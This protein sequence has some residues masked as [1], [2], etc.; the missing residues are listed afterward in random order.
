VALSNRFCEALA[1]A[2]RL[3]AAQR[4]KLSGSPYIGHLLRVTGIALEHGADEDEAIAAVLHD[5]VEDQGGPAT[6]RRIADT[7]GP[8]VAEIVDGCTDSDQQPKPPWRGRKEG[9]LA[10][11]REASPSVRLVA[12]SDKLDNA[13]SILSSYLDGGEA[14]W[15]SFAAGATACSGIC[16]ASSRPSKSRKALLWS[17]SWIARC[18]RS[19]GPSATPTAVR[20]P[21]TL[22]EL[23]A[24][25]RVSYPVLHPTLLEGKGHG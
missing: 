25:A 8:R 15:D 1:Y 20:W 24:S 11:L 21:R 12:A 4:R 23:T 22:L 3:H 7:F 2:T 16:G 19:S 9:F 5:A 6:R 14:I 13:R 18:R 10:R 17:T